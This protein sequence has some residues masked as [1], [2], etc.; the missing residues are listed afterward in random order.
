MIPVGAG[1]QRQELIKVRPERVDADVEV[2][3][4]QSALLSSRARNSRAGLPR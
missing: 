1:G 3:Q 2:G 4:S